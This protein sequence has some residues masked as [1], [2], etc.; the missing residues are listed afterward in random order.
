MESH[1]LAFP[2]IVNMMRVDEHMFSKLIDI[3]F[4]KKILEIFEQ[5][6]VIVIR[7]YK[8]F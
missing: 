4:K 3:D 5:S 6:L 1:M 2:F 8:I 7:Y